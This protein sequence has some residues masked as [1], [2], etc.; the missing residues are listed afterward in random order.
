M[1]RRNVKSKLRYKRLL[2][3]LGIILTMMATGL[4][5]VNNGL[6]SGATVITFA[7]ILITTALTWFFWE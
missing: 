5:A 7:F 4:S 3:V 2:F 6:D 1:V